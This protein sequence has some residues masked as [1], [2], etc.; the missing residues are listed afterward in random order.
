MFMRVIFWITGVLALAC[1]AITF[2]LLRRWHPEQFW[3]TSFGGSSL[4][5][6]GV[7]HCVAG[8][9]DYRGHWSFVLGFTFVTIAAVC[10]GLILDNV[11]KSSDDKQYVVCFAAFFFVCG[12]FSLWSAHKLHR[13][14]VELES[15]K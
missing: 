8:W 14:S 4:L 15:R 10:V 6:A 13:C 1:A 3:L 12:I 7:S 5:I 2:F 11:W 9:N